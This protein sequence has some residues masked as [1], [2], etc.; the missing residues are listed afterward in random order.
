MKLKKKVYGMLAAVLLLT[1]VFTE[2]QWLV[3]VHAETVKV[4]INGTELQDDTYYEFGGFKGSGTM[5]ECDPDAL[6][7]VYLYY[8]A[9]VMQVVGNVRI[10]SNGGSSTEVLKIENGTLTLNGDGRFYLQNN[11]DTETL[12]AGNAAAG[13]ETDGSTDA[14]TGYA[15]LRTDD[16]TGDIV[17]NRYGG[18]SLIKGLSLVDLKTTGEIS[19]SSNSITGDAFISAGSVRLEASNLGLFLLDGTVKHMIKATDAQ[20]GEIRLISTGINYIDLINGNS[21]NASEAFFKAKDVFVSSNGTSSNR[22]ILL[23]GEAIA[24]GNLKIEAKSGVALDAQSTAVN[25]N[26]SINV[27]DGGSVTVVSEGG[28]VSAG[29]TEIYA[30]LSTVRLQAKGNAAAIEGNAKI[31]AE[32]IAMQSVNNAA[33]AGDAELQAQ[34]G[35]E[36]IGA[37]GYPVIAGST[38]VLNTS[39]NEILISRTGSAASDTPPILGGTLQT[40]NDVV[41]YEDGGTRWVQ[42]LATGQVYYADNCEHPIILG[43][44]GRCM[45]CETSYIEYAELIGADGTSKVMLNGDLGGG[46]AHDDLQYL[47]DGDTI[48]LLRDLYANGRTVAIADTKAVTFDLNGHT[49]MLGTLSAGNDLTITNGNYKGTIANASVNLTKVLT[50]R[51]AKATLG[52][53]QWMTDSGVKL[54]ASEVTVAGNNSLEQCWLEKLTMDKDSKLVLNN[55]GDGIGNYGHNTLEE[56]LG[57]IQEFLPEGYSLVRRKKNPEDVDDRNTINDPNGE[58][59]KSVVLRYR[60]MTD[61]DVEVTLNPTTYTYDK[62]AKEPEVLVTYEGQALVKDKDYTAAY[63]DNIN[64]GSAVVTITGMGIYHD[65]AQVHFTIEKAVQTAPAGL[66]AVNVSKSGAKDGAIEK[67]TTAMEYST[68]EVNWISVTAGTTVSGLA[69]G[70]YYVRYAETENYQASP[71]TKVVITAPADNNSL[72]DAE[73]VVTLGATKY[74]YN[75]KA[76][77]PSVK[78]VT[79]A[80]K[81]LKAGTDYTVTYKNNKNIGK[82]SVVITGKGNYTGSVT[83]TFTI[84]AKKGTTVTSGAYKYKFTGASQ[85]AF[86]GIKSTKTTKVVIPKTVKIGGKTFKVTSIAKKALYNK[87]KVKSVTIG[88]NVKTIG[89]SAFQ[90]CKKLSTITIKTTKLKSA[91]KNT[92]K[93]IKANA[94]IKVPSKK[95]KAYKKLLK[96][97]GQGSKVKIV[98]K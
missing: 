76:K 25:G 4:S 27:T 58:I 46:G 48:K 66:T 38:I 88:A 42:V 65:S 94:K 11:E 68:D 28:A 32:R 20:N 19:F 6:P 18:D 57:S 16:Y 24:E 14:G 23:N 69:A 52:N 36:L 21:I 73:T 37:E 2:V 41:I 33:I 10:Y 43:Y 40:G 26:L 92:F 82:A 85:V 91:G 77:K 55:V 49:L 50:F 45:V 89:A 64:A 59:A 13:S 56:S 72:T 12:I 34:Y 51:N 15:A 3:P 75:G 60:R 8:D 35:I 22:S 83:K 71:S 7:S 17:L 95:L 70:N 79:L 9:G 90:N 47:E 84:Y 80:G 54:E 31:N 67:L 81:K 98:K 61:A 62:T 74:A 44:S 78:S 93:G 97:K 63:A 53:L 39:G 5:Q 96:S 1:N 30:P 29:N 86:A 87:S